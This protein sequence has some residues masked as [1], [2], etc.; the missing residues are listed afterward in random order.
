MKNNRYKWGLLFF[1]HISS[2]PH[3][4]HFLFF[5]LND[6]DILLVN[7]MLRFCHISI[8]ILHECCFFSFLPIFSCFWNSLR[9]ACI[10][11]SMFCNQFPEPF[12]SIISKKQRQLV[13]LTS[14]KSDYMNQKNDSCIC[15]S[16]VSVF[17]HCFLIRFSSLLRGTRT[18]IIEWTLGKFCLYFNTFSSWIYLIEGPILGMLVDSIKLLQR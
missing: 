10:V 7:S 15:W 6:K 11:L 13:V 18:S 12:T 8:G 2:T 17:F 1:Q 3:E 9:T 5:T 14:D 16:V 4:L